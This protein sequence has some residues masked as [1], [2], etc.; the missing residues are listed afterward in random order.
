MAGII[1]LS[2]TEAKRPG[3]TTRASANRVD[4]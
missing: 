4:V 1:I 2:S 3:Y